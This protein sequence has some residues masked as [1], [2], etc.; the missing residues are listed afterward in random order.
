M[1]K[2][3]TFIKKR[4]YSMQAY[5]NENYVTEVIHCNSYK[6]NFRTFLKILKF[7]KKKLKKCTH[8][9]QSKMLHS[10]MEHN[11]SHF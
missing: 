8:K 4:T 9:I 3:E 2:I 1:I 5:F 11:L 10:K 6:K 7:I